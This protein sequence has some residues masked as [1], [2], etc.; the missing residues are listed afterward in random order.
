MTEQIFNTPTS[1]EKLMS[2]IAYFFG[3]FG[4]IIVWILQK[5]KSRF[6][7]FHATQA[8]AF[9]FIVTV[10]TGVIFFCIFG[11]M[12]VGMLGTMFTTINSSSPSEGVP[13]FI[14]FSTMMPFT[15]FTCVFPITIILT[16]I[17]VVAAVSVLN[18]RD[19]RY[20]W[21]GKQVEKFLGGYE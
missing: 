9:D 1:D 14:L 11:V 18:G 7:R 19:F 16:I 15:I 4:A 2:A 5:D 20:L 8:L 13:L 3:I 6:V 12:F 10:T 17:R 21:L